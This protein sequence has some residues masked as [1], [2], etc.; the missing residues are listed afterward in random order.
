M[1]RSL[2]AY[3]ATAIPFLAIDFVWLNWASGA[4]YRPRLGNLLLEQPNIAAAGGFYLIYAVA[5]T[6]LVVVPALDRGAWTH[7][8]M[9]GALFGFA[10]YGTYDMTNLS[11]LR[12]W[13]VTVTVIDMAWGTLLTATAATIGF[14]VT[15]AIH[16]PA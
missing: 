14:F 7:A 3:L 6:A 10:A 1:S 15:R 12:G 4:I 13:S 9:M 11:T 2:V 5:V 8:L 16:P